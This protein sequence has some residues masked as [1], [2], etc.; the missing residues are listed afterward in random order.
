MSSETLQQQTPLA[1]LYADFGQPLRHGSAG[2]VLLN[3]L[4]LVGLANLRADPGSGAILDALRSG[5]G[6][7]L[8]LVPNTV[9]QGRDAMALWLGPD[10]WL[11]RAPS[12]APADLAAHV[13]A[14]LAG[15]WFAVTDQTSGH[16]VVRLRGPGARDVLNAGCP[17]DLHPRV[18]TLGQC[19][20]SHFFKA[21]VLLRPLDGHG[22]G[23]ELI[24]RRSFADYVVRM[25]LDA[26]RG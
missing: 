22:D 12:G 25:L 1:G 5:L 11:L 10:E 26:M 17:L 4:P 24:V 3:E 16:S 8:P 7:D 20:Q 23:W 9:A 13:E 19:A 2:Q 14:A 18:L 6:L 15:H 21:S